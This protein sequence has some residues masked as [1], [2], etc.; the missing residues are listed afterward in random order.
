MARASLLIVDDSEADRYIMKRLLQEVEADLTIFEQTNG[1]EALDFIKDFEGNKARYPGEFPPRIIILDINMPL[2][3]GHETLKEFSQL[4]R[5][6]ELDDTL[7]YMYTSSA[8]TDDR[9][10]VMQYDFVAGLLIKG[11]FCLDDL[12]KTL[13]GVL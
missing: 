9:E 3:D 2:K 7:V 1:Q 5:E 11:E 6:Y 8:R 4:R 12:N 10:R 13:L